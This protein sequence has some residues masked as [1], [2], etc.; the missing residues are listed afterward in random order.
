MSRLSALG[1]LLAPLAAQQRTPA[2]AITHVTVIDVERGTRLPQRTVLIEGN[3][4]TAVA[5]SASTRVP[6]NAQLVDG[7][8]RFLIPGLWDMHAHAVVR[9]QIAAPLYLANG[10]LGFRE[11]G[12]TLTL[13]SLKAHR[14]A[15]NAGR[16]VG[17]RFV[18]AGPLLVGRDD[19]QI[20][21]A[22]IV[23][24]TAQDARRTVDSLAAAGADL[25]KVHTC[26]S[27][28]AF[29]AIARAAWSH[30][31][32]FAGHL[33]NV[34]SVAEGSDSGMGMEHLRG[35]EG[36]CST[37]EEMYLRAQRAAYEAGAPDRDTSRAGR[38]AYTRAIN[39]Y[40]P[41]K[42][43]AVADLLARNGTWVTPTLIGGTRFRVSRDSLLRDTRVRYV[44]ARVA[45]T[46]RQQLAVVVTD[47]AWI[48]W[49]RQRHR[50]VPLL[51]EAG[52]GLLV[53]TDAN[54]GLAMINVF[55]GF[56]VHDELAHLVR[57]G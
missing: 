54:L 12:S 51:Q 24:S 35:M 20:P 22:S 29:F 43:E 27:R 18:T 15:V 11:V 3:R 7:R 36:A 48:R 17:P 21:G 9:W 6:K 13:D 56:A 32:L 33:P 28:D 34:V 42:C 14:A 46:W 26:L 19:C 5:P 55:P 8:G 1:L 52:V 45:E 49:Q 41:S 38:E 25:I 10:V 4:I 40:S 37:D 50:I 30:G 53:G 39:S 2:L 31:L 57:A 44:P 16:I 47:S 23:V